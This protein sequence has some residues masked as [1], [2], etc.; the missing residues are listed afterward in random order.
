MCAGRVAAAGSRGGLLMRRT[1]QE[2]EAASQAPGGA[3]PGPLDDHLLYCLGHV[4]RVFGRPFSR[5]A[6]LAGLP[7]R[8]SR[9]SVDLFARAAARAGIVARVVERR[10][11]DIPPT[12]APFIVLT[13]SGDAAVVSR[14]EP[15]TGMLDVVFPQRS[16]ETH[17]V[18]RDELQAK[19]LGHVIYVTP[20]DD[21]KVRA[22]GRHWL[23]PTVRRFWPSW[24]QIALAALFINLLGLAVPLFVM[25]VYDRVIPNFA[26]PTLW[27]LA[28]GVSVALVFEF[29][30]RLLRTLTL[31]RA[32]RRV[33]MRV[34]ADLFEHAMGLRMASRMQP[35]GAVANLIREFETVRDFFTSA[36]IV[37]ATDLLF[38][39]IFVA[40]L[41]LIVGPLAWVP[42]V[43]VPVVIVFALLVQFPLSRSVERTQEQSARRQSILVE[44]LVGI[45]SIKAAGGEGVVQRKWEEAVAATARASASA[46]LWSALALYFTTSVQQAVSVVVIVWGVFLVTGGDITIGA[47]I[48]AN[49]LSSRILSPLGQIATTIAR[50]QQAFSAMRGI[51]GLMALDSELRPRIVSGRAIGEASI[52]FRGVSF[53][54]PGAGRPTLDDVALTIRPGERVGIIGRIGSGKTTF[55]KL[56]A[57][58]HE[59]SSGTLLIGGLDSRAYEIADLR[60]AVAYVPQEADIFAGTL[61]DNILL[62]APGAPEDA[63]AEAARI[64]GV[65]AF[66]ATDP[67]GLA[68]P[69]GE[70][71]RGLSGGQRQALALARML[72]REPR[73]LFLDESSNAMDG[74]SEAQLVARLEK[75]LG[76]DRT[77]IVSTHRGAFLN[78]VGRLIVLDQGRV[79]A[80]GPRDKVL[81]T[82]Q[83]GARQ[84]PRQPVVKPRATGSIH[85]KVA[86]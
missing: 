3:A 62:G 13:R 63:V 72:A 2:S 46:R 57:G 41:W 28:I 30:F 35:A 47:L 44:S 85:T 50:A 54:Y 59:V 64:A 52:E 86:P 25:N 74:T 7:L 70:R 36:S 76:P 27:A 48:A 71:G 1:E 83:A 5:A 78:H 65:D 75:W 11:A 37:A 43:A 80:D 19:I 49:I 9:L 21:E 73:I 15:Q 60:Q 56:L 81:A 40:V 45:E 69:V 20:E 51:S 18:P 68:M 66:A 26:L 31:D 8:G 23:W 84:A 53:T 61:R 16:A 34:A 33:D 38:I 82:L 55:G 24:T 29:M 12:V 4:A 22:A 58:F 10:L 6:I 17:K 77:L 42:L 67:L 14:V 32:G 79:V 39:G